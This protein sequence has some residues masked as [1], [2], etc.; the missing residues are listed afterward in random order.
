MKRVV[1]FLL[2]LLSLYTVFGL[3]LASEKIILPMES[4]YLFV[5][6]G[7]IGGIGGI[8]YC[9]RGVYLNTCVYKRWDNSWLP[10][11]FIRPVVSFICGVVSCLFLKAGLF[12][13]EANQSLNPT[14]LGF[15]SL[16]FV[17]G[18]NVDK[19]TKKIEDIAQVTW[20]IEPTRSQEISK[21]N[22]GT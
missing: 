19:F 7:V 6:C 20:G 4:L 18:L 5:Y 2:I 16:A 10:W 15:L 1:T 3:A 13:L 11:Y 8:T 21:G 9:L 17:A 14:N 12:V 22:H